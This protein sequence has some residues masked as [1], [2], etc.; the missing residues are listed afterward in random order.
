M[1]VGAA[2]IND[3][4]YYS[5]GYYA[6]TYNN[7]QGTGVAL[8]IGGLIGGATFGTIGFVKAG[9]N[10]SK[11]TRIRREILRRGKEFLLNFNQGLIR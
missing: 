7:N 4:Y 5:N 11:A 9:R 2:L 6:S 3:N 8:L 1:G 10:G